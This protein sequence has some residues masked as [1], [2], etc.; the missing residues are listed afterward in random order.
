VDSVSPVLTG[1]TSDQPFGW[2]VPVVTMTAQGTRYVWSRTGFTMALGATYT[3][4]VTGLVGVVCAD[5]PMGGSA[6]VS[7]GSACGT[8]EMFTNGAS[9]DV[10]A[11]SLVTSAVV[12]KEQAPASPG[13]GEALTYRIMV[14]NIGTATISD[15]VVADTVS[16]VLTGLTFSQPAGFG[17]PVITQVAGGT[18]YT[19][20]RTGFN[21]TLGATYTFTVTGKVGVV[22]ADTPVGGTA[23]V[24]AGSACTTTEMYTNGTSCVVLAASLMTNAAVSKTQVPPSPG[25]GEALT[26]RIVVRNTG[27]AT[28]AELVV[29]DTVSPVMVGQTSDQPFGWPVPLR[30]QGTCGPGPGS[31][32]CRAPRTRSR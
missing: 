18:Q 2:P 16:P 5:T 10:L 14:T 31:R 6:Y 17:P 24:A 15:L 1:Q 3:F 25:I 11:A 22:C 4:T 20:S 28:I 12:A 26:Y 30:A 8:T 21:M 23:Y 9:C 32:C 7:A 27:T 13:I 19:W 29:V